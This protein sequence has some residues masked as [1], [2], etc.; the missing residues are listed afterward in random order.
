[1]SEHH[2]HLSERRFKSR[3]AAKRP[4]KVRC[5]ITKDLHQQQPTLTSRPCRALRP[6]CLVVLHLHRVSSPPS[7]TSHY[8]H[9]DPALRVQRERCQQSRS[10]AILLILA[11]QETEHGEILQLEECSCLSVI[12]PFPLVI[13]LDTLS[14]GVGQSVAYPK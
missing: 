12:A 3:A 13:F 11:S 7:Q 9:R 5:S 1:M 14:I 2:T 6:A 4:V 8:R 10:R